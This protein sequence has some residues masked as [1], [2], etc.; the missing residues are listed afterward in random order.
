MADIF[1]GFRSFSGIE[2]IVVPDGH[3]LT[4]PNSKTI[5][6]VRKGNAVH[7]GRTVYMVDE[8]CEA[9]KAAFPAPPPKPQE[10]P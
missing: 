4:D 2:I 5:H 3:K 8:D 6:Y 10:T 7:N 1:A 9:L